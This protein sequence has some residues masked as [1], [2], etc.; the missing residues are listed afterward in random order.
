MLIILLTSS[1]SLWNFFFW[2]FYQLLRDCCQNLQH[3]VWNCLIL[4]LKCV[5]F[6][7][8]YFKVLLIGLHALMIIV[9]YRWFDHFIMNFPSISGSTFCLKVILSD[10]TLTTLIL[11]CLL[12]ISFS[13]V[14]FQPFCIFIFKVSILKIANS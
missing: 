1:L 3:G 13:P 5:Y 6:C 8:K 14:Y 2:L 9:S 11:L 12:F 4:P 10:S 7:F